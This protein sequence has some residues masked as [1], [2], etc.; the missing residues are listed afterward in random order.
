MESMA[1][2]GLYTK[3]MYHRD[4]RLTAQVERLDISVGETFQDL[5]N[6]YELL[7]EYGYKN[8]NGA[9]SLEDA[10]DA[11]LGQA[12]RNIYNSAYDHVEQ[13]EAFMEFVTKFAQLAKPEILEQDDLFGAT[14][15][16]AQ[17]MYGFDVEFDAKDRR[18]KSRSA[19]LSRVRSRR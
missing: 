12:F 18:L 7:K 5:G 11:R 6:K 14:I 15:P 10:S 16:K 2:K 8:L 1:K 13:I 17:G 3:E 19:S 4:K 9:D